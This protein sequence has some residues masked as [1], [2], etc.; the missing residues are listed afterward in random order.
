MSDLEHATK[1]CLRFRCDTNRQ[2]QIRWT[3]WLILHLDERRLRKM[4]NDRPLVLCVDDNE[5]Q[6]H[7]LTAI[8]ERNGFA[9]LQSSTYEL[10]LELLREKPVNVV[11]ADHML[12]GKTGTQLAADMK[13]IKPTVP[14]VLHSGT[15]PD[16][17]QNVDAFVH[18]GESMRKFMGLVRDLVARFKS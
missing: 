8:F 15:N 6:L 12:R 9:V 11:I 18:K 2:S 4:Q 3:T 16:T 13:K 17:M 10:A 1:D 14:V 5:A 7:L